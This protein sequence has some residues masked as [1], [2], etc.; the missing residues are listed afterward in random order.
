MNNKFKII[1][2]DDYI[3]A[4]SDGVKAGDYVVT[5]PDKDIVQVNQSTYVLYDE[6]IIAY[7]PK[8]NA[9]E[10]DLPL[11]PELVMEDDVKKLS[12]EYA[13]K[14]RYWSQGVS[15]AFIAGYKVATK[16]YSEEDLRKAFNAGT[17]WKEKWKTVTDDNINIPDVN[18]FIQSLKQPK[19]PKLFVA[20]IKQSFQQDKSKRSDPKNGVYYKLK[21]TTINGKEYLVGTF[22]YE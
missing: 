11:L 3:L 19:T 13:G 17:H 6:K 7:Q 20:E 2:T 9:P 1:E 21:T 10:L 22:L 8:N 16:V 4:V 18:K 14:Q 12:I 5:Y 15:N